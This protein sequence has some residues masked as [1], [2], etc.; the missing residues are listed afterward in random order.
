MQI[1]HF[2]KTA[3]HV[4]P[5]FPVLC[6]A[7]LLGGQGKT[8]LIYLLTLLCHE[9]G[10]ILMAGRYGLSIRRLEL[11]P[12]GGSMQIDEAETLPARQSFVLAA[13]GVCVNALL[14]FPLTTLFIRTGSLTCLLG[15]TVNLWML[16]LN[17]LP[18]L[19]LDGGRM[20]LALLAKRLDRAAAFRALLMLGRALCALL[21]I[22]ALL[23]ALRGEG[24]MLRLT[25]GCYLLYASAL[26]EKT[27]VSR[28]LAAYLSGRNRIEKSGALPVQHLC[29]GGD[30][31]VTALLSHLH[32]GAYHLVEV[33]D[34]L[35][36]S[37]RLGT[38]DEEA[39]LSALMSRPLAALSSLIR[40]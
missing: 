20:L 18:V 12:F 37:H 19:P 7:Y 13:G 33:L 29:A 14:L 3:L 2:H 32:G 9:C 16:A 21:L 24:A 35:D 23:R 27:S 6:L 34:P 38:L 1:G 5:L 17:L 22:D 39:L 15:I 30:I 4:H 26:E 31:T 10:H 25:L 11:T 28:Y 40:K 8:L 36:A